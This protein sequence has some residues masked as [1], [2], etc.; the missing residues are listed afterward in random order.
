MAEP[1]KRSVL[2]VVHSSFAFTGG[3]E[4][5]AARLGSALVSRG[6]R[7]KAVALEGTLPTPELP[8]DVVRLPQSRIRGFAGVA[9]MIRL[10]W[11]LVRE[12]T[13]YGVI[14][15]HIMKTMAFVAAIVGKTLGKKVVL[16]VSGYDELDHGS[17]N[18]DQAERAYY[19]L[20][21]WGFRKADV[22]IAISRRTQ[23]RLQ[24]CGYRESQVVYLPNG[25]DTARFCPSSDVRGQ[26]R[27]L[28]I[29][30]SHLAVF[31]GRFVYEKG[32]PALLAAWSSVRE[33][34][35]EALLCLVGDGVLRPELEQIVRADA[36]LVR[37][38]HFAGETRQVEK[39]LAAADCYVGASLTEGLSNTM[40]EAMAAGLP[41][42][43]TRVSGAEDMIKDGENGFLVPVGQP[44]MMAEKIIELFT[45]LGR[46]REMGRNSRKLAMESFDLNRV[47]DRYEYLYSSN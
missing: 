43:C 20:L 14:H 35:P 46:A 19:R 28:G 12:R 8:F 4:I 2:T 34:F 6:W 18:P 25:I 24:S 11:F 32:L 42:V 39:Y 10:G 13:T 3:A 47:I 7:V 37:G 21:N 1:V 31:V 26:R 44:G 22:I 17:L 40:L 9:L 41:V 5:Q 38:V 33:R 36:K 30:A 45:D 27:N 23:E 16:K 15:V 29:D